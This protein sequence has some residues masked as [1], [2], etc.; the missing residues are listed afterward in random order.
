MQP[1]VRTVSEMHQLAAVH[2]HSPILLLEVD[3]VLQG[4]LGVVHAVDADVVVLQTKGSR[5]ESG[6]KEALCGSFSHFALSN[7]AVPKRKI[8]L[9][10]R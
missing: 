7:Q 4:V 10:Q 1:T 9:L 2:H 6:E 5:G 8:E 3:H